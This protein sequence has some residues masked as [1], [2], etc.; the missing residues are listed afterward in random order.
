MNAF[1]LGALLVAIEAS[2]TTP[3]ERGAG[4][5]APDESLTYF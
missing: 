1:F 4:D 3:E 5:P 2:Y